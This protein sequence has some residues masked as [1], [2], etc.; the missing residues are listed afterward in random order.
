[1]IVDVVE[2]VVLVVPCD[3]LRVSFNVNV[4]ERSQESQDPTTVTGDS[5]HFQ[6]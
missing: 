3:E 5:D 6:Q 1:L 4:V 2:I